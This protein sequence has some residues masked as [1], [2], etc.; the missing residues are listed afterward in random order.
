[1]SEMAKVAAQL[2][3]LLETWAEIDTARMDGEVSL[4]EQ[5]ALFSS[6]IFPISVTWL[7]VMSDPGFAEVV[8]SEL[9]IIQPELKTASEQ[10]LPDFLA[11]VKEGK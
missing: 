8:F 11:R 2:V 7:M 6:S 3:Y 10:I 1:M 9:E 4:E 5:V